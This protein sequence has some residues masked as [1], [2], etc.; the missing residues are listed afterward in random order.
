MSPIREHFPIP[1]PGKDSGDEGENGS[2]D[3]LFAHRYPLQILIAEDSY[4]NRRL[5]LLLLHRL[6]YHAEYV[7]NGMECLTA[8]LNKPYD[9][10]LSDIEMPEMDGIECASRLRQA[11]ID[12]PI[13]AVTANPPHLTRDRCFE[14]GMNGYIEKPVTLVGL[15]HL[16]RETF[17]AKKKNFAP[18][19]RFD[20]KL[21]AAKTKRKWKF[22]LF[23]FQAA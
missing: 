12:V 5:L 16:L 20:K 19:S 4:I 1:S 10:I 11:G 22:E 14:V 7:D 13:V 17:L 2:P 15:K 23:A 18:S 3:L 6:G 8:A 9:L 21:Y